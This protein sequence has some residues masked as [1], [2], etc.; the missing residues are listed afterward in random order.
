M[1]R[2]LRADLDR[3]RSSY[4]AV[5]AER[6]H[7]TDARGDLEFEVQKFKTEVEALRKQLESTSHTTNDTDSHR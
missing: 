3:V 6:E 5:V 1:I 4:E 7:A 2:T